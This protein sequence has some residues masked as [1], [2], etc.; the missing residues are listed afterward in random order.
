MN[1]LVPYP[2]Y[3][4]A[5]VPWIQRV[6]EHWELHRTKNFLRE[7]NVRSKTGKEDLLSVSQY[8]GITKR[9]DSLRGGSG[10]VTTAKTLVGYKLVEPGDLVMNIMLAWRGSQAVSAYRGIA[11]PAYSV[12]RVTSDN[13]LPEYL[14]YIYRTELYNG[15]FKTVSTGVMD[16]RLRLYPEVFFRLPTLL[17]PKD[18]QHLIVRY[19]HALDAKVKRYIR[20]K[21]S[22]IARL[23]EQ[24]Q[25]IIQ[26]AVTRG[27][28]PNVKLKPSGVEWLGE[29]PEHW[30]E[31]PLKRVA[32][33]ENTGS[34]GHDTGELEMPVATTA[35]ID[36][37]GNFNVE[38]MPRRFF[39]TTE[40]ERYT[41]TTGD[42]LVVKSSGS[43]ANVIS[44]KCGIIRDGITPF[45]FSN[46][47]LRVRAV[48]S[49]IRPEYL[50]LLLRS[51]ITR[52]RIKR[53][54]SGSTYP[55]LK[56]GEY[57][58]AM[59]PIPP[60]A[61]QDV[62]LE[63]L[64]T[65]VGS[66][67]MAE[68]LVAKDIAAMQEYHTRLIADVVTGAV[69]VTAAAK[70]MPADQMISGSDDQMME[71]EPLSMAAEGEEGYGVEEA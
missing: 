3:K 62:I 35:Q 53:M 41:C 44:G 51:H 67:D 20:A 6:P 37:D 7:V 4:P 34:W 16:S 68:A 45:V 63:Q 33:F 29:V 26:R 2:A 48:K 52:E 61:E 49:A 60:L 38:A 13:V 30:E 18:E 28:D 71:E 36:R 58:A 27:L 40:A 32:R 55:N 69:D 10:L 64:L 65:E 21:R 43:M 54:V 47:L 8:T 59:F 70:A 5:G 11:S 22:L 1:T 66:I 12:F 17:P 57:T 23:Q 25:A 31:L 39:S 56:V 46:F 19:L 24:K 42:I 50:F 9:K 14:H 15:L